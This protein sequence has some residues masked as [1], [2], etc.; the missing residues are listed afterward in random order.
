[1]Q[2]MK[3]LMLIAFMI[4]GGVTM[5]T[6]TAIASS[7]ASAIV[8]KACEISPSLAG[9]DPGDQKLDGNPDPRGLTYF[10]VFLNI[11][12]FAA[13]I[14]AFVFV[15][16]GGVRYITSTGDPARIESAKNT[17]LYAIIGLIITVLAVPISAFIIN[18]AGG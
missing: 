11:F 10:Q 4:F 18:A 13:G 16:I 12:L 7:D 3:R 5:G 14:A 8:G 9:C 2:A 17:L 15:I 6:A 1:M